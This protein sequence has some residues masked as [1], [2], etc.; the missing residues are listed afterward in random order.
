MKYQNYS[1]KRVFSLC[2]IIFFMGTFALFAQSKVILYK[3]YNYKGTERQI[4]GNVADLSQSPWYF[5]NVA[6]SLKLQGVS[7]IA[8][9]ELA[10]FGG[11]CETITRDIPNLKSTFIGNDKISSLKLNANCG[12]APA[13]VLYEHRNYK[14]KKLRLTANAA[15]LSS[16][17]YKFNDITSSLKLDG[18]SRVSLYDQANFQG[19]CQT[20]TSNN[21]NL[22]NTNL[23]H[24]TVTSVK[25]NSDCT[26]GGPH[27]ILYQDRNFSGR[28]VRVTQSMA[29]LD[30]SKFNDKLS[31]LKLVNIGSI[32]VY[33]HDNFMGKCQTFTQDARDMSGSNVGNDKASSIRLNSACSNFTRL[34]IKNKS[35]AVIAFWFD[36]YYPDSGHH[37]LATLRSKV[38]NLQSGRAVTIVIQF[39]Y[40]G[41]FDIS[42]SEECRYTIRMDKNTTV[43]ALGTLFNPHCDVEYEY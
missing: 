6:S 25:I 15:N 8:V 17:S 4:S 2:L 18:A 10:N 13:V 32:A 7:S 39:G 37:K 22:G 23:E 27:V 11:T 5:N 28:S 35:A 31:S 40:P 9:Y 19:N 43:K 3:N 21:S 30:L 33:E 14:G 29:D 20:F 1:I 36:N 26:F 16:G 42:Y 38:Y 24:D 34:E 12:N 41:A